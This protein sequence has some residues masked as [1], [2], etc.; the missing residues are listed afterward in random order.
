MSFLLS[1]GVSC[2][3]RIS[4]FDCK[5]D[6]QSYKHKPNTCIYTKD[7]R[8]VE[9]SYVAITHLSVR[10][11]V[12]CTLYYTFY[13]HTRTHTHTSDLNLS[14]LPSTNLSPS[15][16]IIHCPTSQ[17]SDTVISNQKHTN[18]T[19]MVHTTHIQYSSYIV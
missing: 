19:Q 17:H 3:C 13:T 12:E 18:G 16:N 9:K 2:T 1:L 5:T 11:E 8:L 7:C 15:I 14:S 10:T 6:K 4:S